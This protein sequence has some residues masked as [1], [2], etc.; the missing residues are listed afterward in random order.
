MA[1]IVGAYIPLPK[2]EPSDDDADAP[3]PETITGREWDIWQ[4]AFS[5]TGDSEYADRRL[6]EYLRHL[7]S[8]QPSMLKD[9]N[10]GR[11]EG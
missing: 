2:I 10:F 11:P 9:K 8:D 3:T 1:R 6:R 5:E 4:S 7:A